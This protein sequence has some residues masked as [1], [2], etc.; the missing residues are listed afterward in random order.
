MQFFKTNLKQFK[1]SCGSPTNRIFSIH[2]QSFI[3]SLVAFFFAL[4][5]NLKS[6]WFC[7]YIM[8]RYTRDFNTIIKT[9][10]PHIHFLPFCLRAAAKIYATYIIL[11][12]YR[13]SRLQKANSTTSLPQA[14][15]KGKR[16]KNIIR[17][18]QK[19]QNLPFILSSIS[20]NNSFDGL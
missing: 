18:V 5:S 6:I 2:N 15:K 17:N 4:I 10:L 12:L 3:S 19:K 1:K 7:N 8:K 14:H 16:K 9:H 20:C 13:K 11:C